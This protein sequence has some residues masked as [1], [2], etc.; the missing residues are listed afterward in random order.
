MIFAVCEAP[1]L[2]NSF[3]EDSAK[4]CVD[5]CPASTAPP[6]FCTFGYKS[7]AEFSSL[8]IP[9]ETSELSKMETSPYRDAIVLGSYM[10]NLA[11]AWVLLF[12]LTPLLSL[13]LG[14]LFLRLSQNRKETCLAGL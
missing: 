4:V 5:A 9:T 10:N 7:E 8:C 1:S 3:S 6:S 12:I 2:R 14:L 13:L 11:H